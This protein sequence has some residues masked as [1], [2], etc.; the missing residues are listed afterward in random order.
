MRIGLRKIRSR[1]SC[2]R[3]GSDTDSLDGILP[4]QNG[5]WLDGRDAM[6][7]S[8]VNYRHAKVSGSLEKGL[9]APESLNTVT[10]SV[11]PVG[12]KASADDSPPTPVGARSPKRLFSLATAVAAAAVAAEEIPRPSISAVT[13]A[14]KP[15][16][17][18]TKLTGASRFRQIGWKVA[19]S[20]K[21]ASAV[22]TSGAGPALSSATRSTTLLADPKRKRESREGTGGTSQKPGRLIA[23][24]PKLKNLQVTHTLFDHT[25]L[26]RHLQFSPN[27]KLLATCG[28]DGTA[29]LF[30]VPQHPTEPVGKHKILAA[31]GFLGQ[32]AWSRDGKCL[33]VKWTTGI[34]VWGEVSMVSYF[35][36]MGLDT[37]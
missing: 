11:I 27:G 4:F 14:A 34:Q 24:R 18:N 22:S 33:L 2:F 13:E 3:H 36:R 37:L 29:R 5:G 6:S 26:V 7:S 1:L 20:Q 32:V 31:S 30:E 10:T 25:A 12:R 9:G 16:P 19:A 35:V 8:P 28:W 17:A 21:E 23:I 15:T